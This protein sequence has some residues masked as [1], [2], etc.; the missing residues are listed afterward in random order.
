MINPIDLVVTADGQVFVLEWWG[1]RVQ[2]WC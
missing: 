2:V 1:H